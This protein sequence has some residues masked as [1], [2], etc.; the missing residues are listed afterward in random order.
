MAGQ[1]FNHSFF[2][3]SS[4]IRSAFAKEIQQFFLEYF[5]AKALDV[6][7]AFVSENPPFPTN[8]AI[9]A[10]RT[11]YG[12]PVYSLDVPWGN[13]EP[14]TIATEALLDDLQVVVL[15]DPNQDPNLVVTSLVLDELAKRNGETSDI[16]DHIK[17]KVAE[18]KE[19]IVEYDG[20]LRFTP[21]LLLCGWAEAF[22]LTAFRQRINS[23][24]KSFIRR[25]LP[26]NQDGKRVSREVHEFNYCNSSEQLDLALELVIA[27]TNSQAYQGNM[28]DAGINANRPLTYGDFVDWEQ[29]RKLIAQIRKVRRLLRGANVKGI[30]ELTGQDSQALET[31]LLDQL[32]VSAAAAELETVL[33]L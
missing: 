31:Q 20:Q 33:N 4:T 1:I 22:D 7:L 23:A 28:D 8:D 16:V 9:V 15:E 13:N 17:E 5:G 32:D 3:Q 11:P 12:A 2:A 25:C 30:L 26:G 21:E 6:T 19:Q 27:F 10:Y 29:G 24:T 14:S 18:R